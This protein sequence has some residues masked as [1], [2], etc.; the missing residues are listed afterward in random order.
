MAYQF[1][2]DHGHRI[3]QNCEK[4]HIMVH[5]LE[6]Q[7][8][9][10]HVGTLVGHGN[11]DTASLENTLTQRTLFIDCTLEASKSPSNVIQVIWAR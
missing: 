10:P 4:A 2:Q 11:Y 7:H 8:N 3:S 5:T 6:M 1:P 9:H